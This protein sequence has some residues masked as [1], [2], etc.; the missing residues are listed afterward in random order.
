MRNAY[1]LSCIIVL[2]VLYPTL[3]LI[4]V[5]SLVSMIFIWTE[6]PYLHSKSA[7]VIITPI[8]LVAALLVF[9]AY[10]KIL[11]HSSV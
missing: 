1:H 7:L 10:D 5:L 9:S 2:N 11:D 4:F 6:Y 3:G 8:L